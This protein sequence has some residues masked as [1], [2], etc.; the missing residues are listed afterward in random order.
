MTEM[1]TGIT[2]N[3]QGLEESAGES[4]VL[5]SQKVQRAMVALSKF[6][7]NMHMSME[8][9]FTYCD[10]SLQK[11]MTMPRKVRLLND[12]TR[13]EWAAI[14]MPTL[15]G[16]QNDITQGE[17][18]FKVDPTVLGETMKQIKFAEAM[19]FVQVL[20]QLNPAIVNPIPLFDLWESPIS[21]EMKEYAQQV[22]AMQTG[23]Q[24]AQAQ[25]QAQ[26]AQIQALRGAGQALGTLNQ[27]AATSM[28]GAG[29]VDNTQGNVGSKVGV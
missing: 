1:L 18:D 6:F 7:G 11:F 4:G 24:Q 22:L 19:G 9:T 20:A 29:P 21:G 16:V 14:N 27:A 15:E 3:A 26:M 8:Q 23:M 12:P 10:R 25:Q 13:P 2:P 28:P 17:F 5:F